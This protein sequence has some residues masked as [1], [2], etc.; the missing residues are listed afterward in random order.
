MMINQFLQKLCR[1]HFITPKIWLPKTFLLCQKCTYAFNFVQGFAF[2]IDKKFLYCFKLA[3]YLG[4]EKMWREKNPVMTNEY[5]NGFEQD[6]VF[7][8][9]L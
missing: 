4:C 9:F 8:N 6:G 3:N 1:K 2:L 7:S 5:L